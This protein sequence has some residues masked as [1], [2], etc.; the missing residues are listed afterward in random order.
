MP[1]T[2]PYPPINPDNTHI[3][4]AILDLSEANGKEF[5]EIK[6]SVGSIDKSVA[7][8][9]E[10]VDNHLRDK[11]IHQA[12]PERPCPQAVALQDD[13]SKLKNWKSYITGGMAALA[14]LIMLGLGAWKV[15]GG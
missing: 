5:G 4:Q 3:M 7:V 12:K 14:F 13:V 1:E 9:I 2:G 6:K 11:V 8:V 10:R 15:F